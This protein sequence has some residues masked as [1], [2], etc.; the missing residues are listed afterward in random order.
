MTCASYPGPPCMTDEADA[1]R[2]SGARD[3]RRICADKHC[4][5]IIP[6][7]FFAA[8][9][10]YVAAVYA[11]PSGRLEDRIF[12]LCGQVVAAGADS[13]EFYALASELRSCLSEHIKRTRTRLA[14][15][16]ASDQCRKQAD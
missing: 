14:E 10:F 15:Y 7:A 5:H 11:V 6:V 2:P 12:R 1:G 4:C 16:P 9:W 8:K 3:L 13:S